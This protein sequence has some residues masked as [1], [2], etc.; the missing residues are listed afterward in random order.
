MYLNCSRSPIL[1]PDAMKTLMEVDGVFPGYDLQEKTNLREKL[2][3]DQN[4]TEKVAGGMLRNN[5]NLY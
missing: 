5:K 1:E 4:K 2:L 3:I